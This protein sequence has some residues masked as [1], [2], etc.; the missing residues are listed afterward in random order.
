M[1]G[2]LFE[3][4]APSEHCWRYRKIRLRVYEVLEINLCLFLGRSR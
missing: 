3:A 2:G 1:V 4:L